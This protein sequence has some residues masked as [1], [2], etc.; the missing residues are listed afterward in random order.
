M[1]AAAAEVDQATQVLQ[2]MEPAEVA[3]PV[4]WTTEV[5][6]CP[7]LLAPP[8]PDQT[9]NRRKGEH[10]LRKVFATAG[11]SPGPYLENI[12]RGRGV[13]DGVVTFL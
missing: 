11:V 2:A 13:L 9:P 7:I 12:A 5:L 3:V 10:F 1:H 8:W 6:H 4:P